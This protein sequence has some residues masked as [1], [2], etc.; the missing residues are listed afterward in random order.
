MSIYLSTW[1]M[2]LVMMEPSLEKVRD[3]LGVSRYSITNCSHA[4]YLDTHSAVPVCSF[5]Q[6][7]LLRARCEP[8]K[9]RVWE[10]P[11]TYRLFIPITFG[12][13]GTPYSRYASFGL[14]RLR[15]FLSWLTV[16]PFSPGET[17]N[18][19]SDR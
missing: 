19:H 2:F 17:T 7:G 5:A 13:S 11:R 8:W 4:L 10:R 16:Q 14:M 15:G 1:G 12:L 3:C 18:H 6:F 9:V